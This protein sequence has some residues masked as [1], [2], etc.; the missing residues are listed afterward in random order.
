MPFTE[1]KNPKNDG[2]QRK[3]G[4]HRKYVYIV[5]FDINSAM[6]IKSATKVK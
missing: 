6:N 5:H 1:F 3:Y 2:I 4:I